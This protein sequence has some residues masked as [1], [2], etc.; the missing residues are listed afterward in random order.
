MRE[1]APE[2]VVAP[3][4]VEAAIFQHQGSGHRHR[5][6]GA[7]LLLDHKNS[8][9]IWR[10]PLGHP[11]GGQDADLGHVQ[12]SRLHQAGFSGSP[13]PHTVSLLGGLV[14]RR[15]A[16]RKVTYMKRAHVAVSSLSPTPEIFSL[17][18]GS[19]WSPF[20]P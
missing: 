10:E 18:P 12:G 3:V 16:E 13:S 20:E 6:Q 8:P 2:V 9:G 11:G 17:S 4:V 7:E 1:G 14:E 5:R 19:S 15:G